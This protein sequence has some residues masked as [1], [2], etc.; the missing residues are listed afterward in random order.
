MNKVLKVLGWILVPYIMIGM[1][2]AKKYNSVSRGIICGLGALLVCLS[3]NAFVSSE[4][5]SNNIAKQEIKVNAETNSETKMTISQINAIAKAK[6]YLNTMA[7]SKK[8]LITQ[9]EYEGFSEKD[10]YFAVNNIK[11][12][13]EEQAINKAKMYLNTMAF[14]K[15]G[16]IDQLIYEGFTEYQAVCA[17]NEIGF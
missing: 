14:S 16:L 10:A 7:F 12:N 2:A 8:G 3:L 15:K 13:W 9:L 4:E 1:L 11:V 17:V 5:V 6:M